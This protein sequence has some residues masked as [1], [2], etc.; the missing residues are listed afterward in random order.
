VA[1]GARKAHEE[2]AKIGRDKQALINGVRIRPLL[3]PAIAQ[4]MWGRGRQD[5]GREGAQHRRNREDRPD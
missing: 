4:R 2:V 1:R 3:S 5:D